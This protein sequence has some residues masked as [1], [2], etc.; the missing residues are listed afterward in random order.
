MEVLNQPN[1][2]LVE[3][4]IVKGYTVEGSRY[5]KEGYTLFKK[6]VPY[7]VGYTLLL[8]AA[9]IALSR[10]DYKFNLIS[11]VYPVFTAG[12]YVVASKLDRDE[13]V[14]FKDFFKGM[15]R[16]LPLLL[17]NILVSLIVVLGLV[18]LILPGVYFLVG[19][20]L[21]I[22]F[23]VFQDLD[24]WPAMKISRKV[25]SKEWFSF[26]LFVL[27][28]IGINVLG[29]LCFVIGLLVFQQFNYAT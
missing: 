29:F 14:E 15:N 22:P 24:F 5:I 10:S 19:Y 8:A 11:L 7:L 6:N 21:V 23:I 26:F 13:P 9:E 28:L 20:T 3:N 4:L 1:E 27:L 18:L 16:F 12:Y 17:A 2:G 25:I